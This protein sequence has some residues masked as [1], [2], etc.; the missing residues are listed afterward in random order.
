MKVI[1]ILALRRLVRQPLRAIIAVISVAAGVSLAIALVIV[2]GSLTT[3]VHDHGRALSGPTPLRVIGATARGGLDQKYIDVVEH[4][5]G[6][7]AAVPMV[8]AVAL[9]EDAQRHESPVLALGI[10]CRIEA[11]VGSFGCSDAT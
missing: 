4:V 1:R 2:V 9:V 10:D 3:S 8:Q 7:E 6:V 11:I 5:D